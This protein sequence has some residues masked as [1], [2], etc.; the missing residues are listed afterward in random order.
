M[1]TQL[2]LLTLALLIACGQLPAQQAALDTT[3]FIVMGGGLSAGVTDSVLIQESQRYC[4]PALMARQ[5]NAIM[6]LPLLRDGGPVP[7][8]AMNMRSNNIPPANQSTLRALPF[9]LFTFN[10][11]VPFLR[12]SEGLSSRPAQP[13]VPDGN[14]K[15][16]LINLVLGYPELT[17]E[18]PVSW[19]QIEYVEMMAPTFVIVEMGFGDV[20]EGALSGDMGKITPTSSFAT[21]YASVAKRLKDTAATVILL[22]VPDPTDTAYFATVDQVAGDLGTGADQLRQQFGIQPGDLITL[23][24]RVEISERLQGRR[25]DPLSNAALLRASAVATVQSAVQ[26]MNSAITGA[27]TTNGFKVFDLY[28]FMREVRTQGV[29]AGSVQLGGNYP[30]GFYSSDGVFPTLTG[31]AVLANRLLDFVNAT[32]RTAY[33]NIVYDSVPRQPAPSAPLGPGIE[34]LLPRVSR[35]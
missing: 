4:F 25:N 31:Y 35:R 21:D 2:R 10:V 6:P 24:G 33:P 27:A 30:G 7:V 20:A 16:S 17:I 3:T 18:H 22:T 1:K 29:R 13:L 23:G 12:V 9:P 32:Y 28:A 15:Q 8:I 34:S 11:S 26:G 19:S 14:Y 5:M